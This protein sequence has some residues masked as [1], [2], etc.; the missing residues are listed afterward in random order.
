MHIHTSPLAH[1]YS[2][3]TTWECGGGLLG[4]SRRRITGYWAFALCLDT[5]GPRGTATS[6]K[7]SYRVLAIVYPKNR[8]HETMSLLRLRLFSRARVVQ[9]PREIDASNIKHRQREPYH[10]DAFWQFP[11]CP[12]TP[13]HVSRRKSARN[14]ISSTPIRPWSRPPIKRV[15]ECYMGL[16]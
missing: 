16:K 8:R 3:E 4:S 5:S 15:F 10:D 11:T 6:T 14:L 2:T 12:P 13:T 1:E 7:P 9:P